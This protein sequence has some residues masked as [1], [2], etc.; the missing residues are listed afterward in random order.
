M[1]ASNASSLVL[2]LEFGLATVLLA[3]AIG[4][5]QEEALVAEGVPAGAPVL[6]V[7]HHG[8]GSSSG[9]RFLAR[10][11]PC[12][13]AISCGARNPFGHPAPGTLVR[14]GEIGAEIH[15]TDREG[16]LWYEL[17]GD[18]PRRL[19]WRAPGALASASHAHAEA[20]AARL[21]AALARP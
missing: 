14:L 18:G 2:R 13:A 4:A 17:P 10:A 12:I 11:R 20:P 9:S 16:A 19:D 8:S 15:R 21:R 7:A 1:T 6:K 3:S 5:A